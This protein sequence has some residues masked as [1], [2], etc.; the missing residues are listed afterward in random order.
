MRWFSR[1]PLRPG[2]PSDG[3]HDPAA[4]V[5]GQVRSGR[6]AKSPLEQL[7]RDAA[8]DALAVDRKRTIQR[9][10][11]RVWAELAYISGAREL[12]A[13]QQSWVEQMRA[14]ARARSGGRALLIVL[15]NGSGLTPKDF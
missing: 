15:R 13:S 2:R 3:L 4:V 10:V 6:Q 14:S 8:A 1:S 12:L 9:E 11:R 5:R 7:P